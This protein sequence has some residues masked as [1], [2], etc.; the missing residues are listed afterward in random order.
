M[1]GYEVFRAIQANLESKHILCALASKSTAEEE[2][3]LLEME[4]FRFY[5]QAD[6]PGTPGGSYPTRPADPLRYQPSFPLIAPFKPDDFK[7]S[8]KG[9]PF[10]FRII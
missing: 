1:D 9:L 6:Q 5:C 4:V 2:A 7:A 10:L 8:K 3:K